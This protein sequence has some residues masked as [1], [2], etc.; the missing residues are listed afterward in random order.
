MAIAAWT[1]TRTARLEELEPDIRGS[2]QR[3]AGA[4][5]ADCHHF[6]IR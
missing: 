6:N 1:G 4:I 5:P 3:I 2:S